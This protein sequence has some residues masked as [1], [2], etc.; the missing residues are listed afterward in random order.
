[1]C[2]VVLRLTTSLLRFG[3]Y[4]CQPCDD[5]AM[6]DERLQPVAFMNRENRDSKNISQNYQ[7]MRSASSDRRPACSPSEYF[8]LETNGS[9]AAM[10]KFS[11]RP[12]EEVN[13]Y[14]WNN[15]KLLAS[16]TDDLSQRS[17]GDR[18]VEFNSHSGHSSRRS[19][20]P[21]SSK[22]ELLFIFTVFMFVNLFLV[23]L[24]LHD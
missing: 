15:R 16:K 24:Q 4:Q 11:C 8:C 12:A 1:M 14:S 10:E 9:D 3:L 6:M 23:L 7:H 19:G 5:I 18:S 2:C 20:I 17:P 22:F 21:V 13:G